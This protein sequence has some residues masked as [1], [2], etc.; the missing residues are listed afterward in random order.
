LIVSLVLLPSVMSLEGIL[1]DGGYNDTQVYMPGSSSNSILGLN[2]G[3]PH[4]RESVAVMFNGMAYFIGGQNISAL[5]QNNYLRDVF[6]FDPKT[7]TTKQGASMT[8]SRRRHS[9]VVVNNTIIVC[10]GEDSEQ[11]H[12]SCEQLN[13]TSNQWDEI[14][15]MKD[16]RSAFAMTTLNGKVYVFGGEDNNQVDTCNS[17]NTVYMFDGQTWTQKAPMKRPIRHHGGVAIDD[18]RA[19]VC[20]GQVPQ[21]GLCQRQGFSECYIYTAS[22][23]KWADAKPLFFGN[24]EFGMT[25]YKGVVYLLGGRGESCTKVERYTLEAGGQF[26]NTQIGCESRMAVVVIDSPVST[27][28]SPPPSTTKVA[29]QTVGS[30]VLITVA[31]LLL[32]YV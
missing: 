3:L 7:N 13:L 31:M 1:I 29:T 28:V 26:E 24:S 11:Y 12:H 32:S 18:D 22:T 25:M 10:G 16:A 9:A 21:H 6:I 8:R 27:T 23:D 14:T 4:Y 17:T 30:C 19:L 15:H 2:F 5:D 20:G